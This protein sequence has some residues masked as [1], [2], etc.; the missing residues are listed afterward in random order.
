VLESVG[1][2]KLFQDETFSFGTS[3]SRSR[4][5]PLEGIPCSNVM[6]LL[7]PMGQWV[8]KCAME[9]GLVSFMTNGVVSLIKQL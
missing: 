2:Q 1:D 7:V 6:V 5:H 9:S 4:I 3:G 8:S